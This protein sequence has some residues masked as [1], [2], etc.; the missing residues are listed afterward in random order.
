MPGS[1]ASKVNF[2]FPIENINRE[3][4]WRLLVACMHASSRNRIFIGQHDVLFR[5][6]T[7]TRMR[8][9]VYVGKHLFRQRPTFQDYERYRAVKQLG[10]LVAHIDEEGAVYEGDEDRWRYWL[11]CAQFDPRCLD[12]EDY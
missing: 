11:V 9:G 3:I 2:L 6:A 7:R 8:G 5:M 12:A 1:A 10:F 4:D